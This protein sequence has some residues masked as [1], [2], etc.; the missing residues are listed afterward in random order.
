MSEGAPRL[1]SNFDLLRLGAATAVVLSHSLLVVTAAA[2]QAQYT[3]SPFRQVGDDALAVFFVVSGILVTRSWQRD[4]HL[5]R[6]LA[7]RAL[8]LMPALV[9]TVAL[10]CLVLGPIATQESPAAY[11]RA[12]GTTSYLLN[13]TLF[14]QP[15]GLPGVFAHLPQGGM[16]N[17]SLWTLRYEFL[18]Y[19]LVPLLLAT[20]TVM[21]NRVLVIAMWVVSLT[22][23]T[24]ALAT[25]SD[26]VL[27]GIHSMSIAGIPGAA[28]WN[29]APLFELMSYFLAGMCIQM[30]LSRIRFDARLAVLAVPVFVVCSQFPLLFPLSVVALAYPVG[31]FGLTARSVAGALVAKGDASYG[32]YVWG[33]VVEQFTVLWFGPKLSALAV[34]AIALPITWA[35]GMLSWCLIEKPA[36]RFKP[37]RVISHHTLGTPAR[38][39][40]GLT[41]SERGAVPIAGIMLSRTGK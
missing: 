33:F 36:L 23:A 10:T 7:R 37:H 29:Y 13:S 26:Y 41:A 27:L 38:I 11:F 22:V 40:T 31:Y 8:R 14:L 5:G 21:R 20:V 15:Y 18:C 17:G 6:Y 24:S 28:G 16:V 19:L 2:S 9:V 12:P 25:G 32:I 3:A 30:W 34:F 35:L 4:P 1:G 39:G